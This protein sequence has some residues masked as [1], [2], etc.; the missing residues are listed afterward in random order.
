MTKFVVGKGF[1]ADFEFGFDIGSYAIV[2]SDVV[3]AD[4][5]SCLVESEDGFD[6]LYEGTGFGNF[7]PETGVP[8]T[9]MV[10]SWTQSYGGLPVFTMTEFSQTW[11][12]YWSFVE[13]GKTDIFLH[14]IF[15]GSDTVVGG[16]LDDSLFGWDGD[17]RLKGGNG[18]DGLLGGHGRDILV[19]GNGYDVL[20]GGK[21]ADI[22]VYRKIADSPAGAQPDFI[23]FDHSQ[24]DRIDLHKIDA[25]TIA[26]GDQAFY[27]AGQSFSFSGTP[28]E[29]I[30]FPDDFRKLVQ[31]DVNGDK[32]AD[33]EIRVSWPTTPVDV[34]FIF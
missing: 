8:T 1:A 32:V 27:L 6:Q 23:L 29:L 9:G 3:T 30:F 28:G 25:D 31:G 15:R 7:D 33:F 2:E 5:Y 19:G 13:S 11:E 26:N 16:R 21:G 20:I 10:T 18:D 34:D 4:E 24:G 17:D 22:F 12:D 14:A